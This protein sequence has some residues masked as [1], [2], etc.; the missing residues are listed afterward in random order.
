MIGPVS[1]AALTLSVGASAQQASFD[2][3][4]ETRPILNRAVAAVKT[5]KNKTLAM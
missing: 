1:T 5:D 4:L 2:K 3:A